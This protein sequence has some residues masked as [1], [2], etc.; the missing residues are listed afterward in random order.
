MPNSIERDFQLALAL[1]CNEWRLGD[2]G[3]LSTVLQ[4]EVCD[5]DET[6]SDRESATAF[7]NMGEVCPECG[8]E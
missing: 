2:N 7:L 5:H 6:F 3:T 8:G 1:R 4:C